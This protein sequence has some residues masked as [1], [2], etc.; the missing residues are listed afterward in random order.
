MDVMFAFSRVSF[1]VTAFIGVFAA[2]LSFFSFL[3]AGVVSVIVPV[4]FLMSAVFAVMS[5]MSF[6]IVMS[7]FPF[8]MFV[9][10]FISFLAGVAVFTETAAVMFGTAAFLPGGMMAGRRQ[11]Y[12]G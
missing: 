9:E 5:F 1:I 12:V 3:V 7:L 4:R 11:A 10:S 2:L 8:R 6:F